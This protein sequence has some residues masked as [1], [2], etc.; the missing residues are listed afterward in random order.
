MILQNL[1]KNTLKR[2]FGAEKF[3]K[4]NGEKLFELSLTSLKLFIFLKGN[5]YSHY[6]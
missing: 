5:R 2:W 4:K 1:G 3:E 6:K